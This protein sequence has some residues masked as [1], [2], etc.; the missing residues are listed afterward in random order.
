MDQNLVLHQGGDRKWKDNTH[1]DYVN[2]YGHSGQMPDYEYHQGHGGHYP[3][4]G[5]HQD[6]GGHYPSQGYHQGHGGYYPGHGYHQWS[7]RGLPRT[8]LSSR[9][10]RVIIQAM[11]TIMVNGS[12]YHR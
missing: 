3:G 9:S 6:H 1:G 10:R 11:V 5:Y 2:P 8:W 4:Q 7:R 12:M